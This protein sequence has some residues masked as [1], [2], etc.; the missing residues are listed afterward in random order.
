MIGMSMNL[1]AMPH[2]WT[3]K[4]TGIVSLTNEEE[5]N[6][7]LSRITIIWCWRH[8]DYSPALNTIFFLHETH[9][10]RK[11]TTYNTICQKSLLIFEDNAIEPDAN[12]SSTCPAMVSILVPRNIWGTCCNRDPLHWTSLFFKV[13]YYLTICSRSTRPNI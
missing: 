11:K 6:A 3:A 4:S 7:L 10:V 1:N 5:P 12:V 8:C 2:E 9:R 13:Q